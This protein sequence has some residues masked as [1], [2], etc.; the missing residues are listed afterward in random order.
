MRKGASLTNEKK[1]T[2]PRIARGSCDERKQLL[3]LG[4]CACAFPPQTRASGLV[5]IPGVAVDHHGIVGLVHAHPIRHPTNPGASG[6][7]GQDVDMALEAVTPAGILEN[8]ADQLLIDMSSRQDAA[9]VFRE[10][11]SHCR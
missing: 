9:A 2:L 7:V 5:V 3:G 4:P 8:I 10:S 6:V 11:C 1:V